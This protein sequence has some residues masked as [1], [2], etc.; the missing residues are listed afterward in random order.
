MQYCTVD[1]SFD[2]V[3]MGYRRS[4]Q[5]N[6]LKSEGLVVTPHPSPKVDNKN[7]KIRGIK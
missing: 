5:V 7:S 1:T 2:D 6:R 3:G 4:P